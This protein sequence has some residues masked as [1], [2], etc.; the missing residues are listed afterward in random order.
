MYRRN[1]KAIRDLGRIDELLGVSATTRN[2]NT[3]RKIVKILK[4]E[5]TAGR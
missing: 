1:M 4:G 5:P 2:W 3:I